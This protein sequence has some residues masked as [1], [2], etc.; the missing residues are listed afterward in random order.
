MSSAD[1]IHWTKINPFMKEQISFI[2]LSLSFCQENTIP[3]SGDSTIITPEKQRED[4]EISVALCPAGTISFSRTSERTCRKLSNRAD[5]KPPKTITAGTGRMAAATQPATAMA[6][7]AN[8][9]P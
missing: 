2:A 4:T 5:R 6:E 3:N 8:T 9:R 1:N 7:T